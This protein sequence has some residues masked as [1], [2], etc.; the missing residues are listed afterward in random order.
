MKPDFKYIAFD[1][2]SPPTHGNGQTTAWKSPETIDVKPYYSAIDTA[3]LPHIGFASG[4]PPFLRGPYATM[5]TTK[6]WTIRQ[7][8]GFSTARASNAF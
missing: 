4:M 7:Y 3:S 1:Q 2:F 6:P 5:Y 8:A